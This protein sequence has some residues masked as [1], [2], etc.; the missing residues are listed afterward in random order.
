MD[1]KA[2]IQEIIVGISSFK[3][4]P[5]F[6]AGMSKAC[7]AL[8]WKGVIDS[9]RGELDNP[10][11][12][13][14]DI[15]QEYEDRFG[16]TALIEKLKLYC[17]LTKVDSETLKNHLLILGMNPPLVY[18]TNYDNAIE[19]AAVLLMAKYKKV[20]SLKDIVELEFGERQIIKFHGDFSDERSIVFTRKDYNTR[21]ELN[22]AM[23]VCFRSNILGKSVLF[24]GYGFGD[25]NIQ[26]IFER[27][28]ELYGRQN[29]PKS[30][31]I[32]FEEDA[33]KEAELREKNVITLHLSEPAELNDLISE[34]NAQVFSHSF[35]SQF[36]SIFHALPT[37]ALTAVDL[38]NLQDYI[39][40]GDFNTQQ[41]CHK[42]RAAIEGATLT[43]D[44]RDAYTQ[45]MKEVAH[46][47]YPDEIKEAVL[48]SF[49]HVYGL[50]VVML[51]GICLDLMYLTDNPKFLLDFENNMWAP[52]VIM[53]IEKKFGEVFTSSVEVRKWVCLMVLGYLEG[54][55]AEQKK[56]GIQQV[57]RLL[58]ALKNNRYEELGDL[59]SGFT[60][61]NIAE[62]IT[63]YLD[64]HPPAL[65]QRF[66]TKSLF[67]RNTVTEIQE[68]LMKSFPEGLQ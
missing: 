31:I 14:L 32:S 28:S 60:P 49:Q 67:K 16:R 10:S 64:E 5:F 34:I 9:L 21:L 13:Y 33:R 57:E 35:H 44:A 68:G 4:I 22:H 18:T 53:I 43:V 23:D 41:K 59:G 48:V 24:L 17:G 2:I 27:H 12:D 47:T 46:G 52:D 15:A 38:K 58:D 11:G 62:T 19:E 29:I 39:G 30:Y 25:E 42:I 7:G 65:K 66:T 50:T 36:K 61:E 3:M 26:L 6:G 8:D 20:V 45:W 63:G 55:R 37:R 1:K 56:L 40:S 54:M 51:V